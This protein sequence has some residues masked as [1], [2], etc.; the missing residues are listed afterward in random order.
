MDGTP[1]FPMHLDRTSIRDQFDRIRSSNSLRGKDQLQKLLNVLY[2][3]IDSKIILRPQGVIQQ[4]WPDEAK[5]KKSRDVATEVARL[6][7]ALDCYYC[8]EGKDDPITIILP[9]RTLPGPGGVRET[10]WIVAEPR[11]AG[12]EAPAEC[13]PDPGVHKKLRVLGSAAFLGLVVFFLLGALMGED[14]PSSGRLDSSM[15]RIMN[16]KGKEIWHKNFPDGFWPDYYA[17][18]LEQRLWIGDLDGTGH[19]EVLFFYHPATGPLSHSTSLICYSESGKERWRWS[20]G[21]NLPELGGSPAA[22][23]SYSFGVL[24]ATAREH[25]RIVVSSGHTMYYANQIAL[26]DGNGKTLSEYWH[27]GHLYHIALANLGDQN[28]QE[29]VATGVSN[30]YR[31]ATLVVLDP[32]RV[33]GAS[34]EAARPEVQI[35]GMGIARE[36]Y[37]LLF[38]RSDLNRNLAVYNQG[39]EPTVDGE[40]IQ[41][42]VMECEL[43][44]RC[45]VLYEFDKGLALVMVV[46]DDQFRSAH[47]QFYLSRA[48][49]HPFSS[50][51]EREFRKVR[52]LVGCLTEFV[53]SRAN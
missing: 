6:R 16:E 29:I 12:A 31:Q 37:R 25:P 18:G 48:D 40:R 53:T 47:K 22:F 11:H 15:L 46:P 51:E 44:P 49:D 43:L 23:T 21:K 34:T 9:N 39:L 30:G 28:Q 20:P 17:Q 7:K 27:S 19:R 14:Q 13:A 32:D 50:E 1:E 24:K 3:S 8:E 42:R 36:K 4:L 38:P 41:L 52:C 35:H 33:S 26:V 45:V 5:T 2:D 10:R